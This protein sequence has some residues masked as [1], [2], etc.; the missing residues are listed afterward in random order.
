M[1]ITISAISFCEYVIQQANGLASLGHLV[2]AIMPSP[3]IQNTIGDDIGSFIST[4]VSVF[5][6]REQRPWKSAYF[7]DPVRAI[8]AFSPDILH[9]HENGE[10]VTLSIGLCFR[11]V[12]LVLSVHD[13]TP[14]PGADSRSNL[15]R[16]TIKAWMRRRATAIH[17]HGRQPEDRIRTRH[18]ALAHKVTVIPHGALSLFSHWGNEPIQRE[19]LTCLFFGRMEK[20]RG[21]D[22]LMV[23]GRRLKKAIPGIRILVA[24]TGTELAKYTSAMA[25]EGI[26]EVHDAFIPN[27]LIPHFFKRASVLLMPYHEASQSGVAAMGLPFGLPVV[28]TDVGA[29]SETIMDGVHGKVVPVGDMEKFTASVIEILTNEGFRK[30]MEKNCLDLS[31]ALSF[32]NLAHDFERLYQQAIGL[33]R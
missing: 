7:S 26:F 17:V 31:Q 12:P 32:E 2:L 11:R 28:A 19:P 27:R 13:V 10:L 25:A 15:R 22:N 24:G 33:R 1:R 29:I 30:A 21:L 20:Y 3:L 18:S 8:A 4:G 23:V 14:H 16:R 6:C 5:K 9:V